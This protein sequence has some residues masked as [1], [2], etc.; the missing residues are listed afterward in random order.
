M[1]YKTN[2]FAKFKGFTLIELAAVMAVVGIVSVGVFTT[3]SEQKTSRFW[4]EADLRL[5]IAKT[6]LVKYAKRNKY[7]PCPDDPDNPDG[8]EDRQSSANNFACQFTTGLIPYQTLNMFVDDARDSWGNSLVYAVNQRA[9]V[10]ADIVSCPENSA[11]FFNN[12][13]APNF[14]WTTPP[15]VGSSVIAADDGVGNL[16]VCS[17]ASCDAST[18]AADVIADN[19]VVVIY[20][21][22]ENGGL[23]TTLETAEAENSDGD[24]FFVQ[25]SYSS[26]PFF[27]D[28]YIGISAN[29]LKERFEAEARILTSEDDGDDL[30]DNPFAN[31]EETVDG[32][33]GDNDRYSKIIGLNIGG[34]QKLDFDPEGKGLFD[35][36]EKTVTI[37]LKVKVE[38][39]WEDGDYN[40][41]V[42]DYET[43][44]TFAVGLNNYWDYDAGAERT[45]D[46]EKVEAIADA[47]VPEDGRINRTEG[48]ELF[49]IDENIYGGDD[50]TE[51]RLFYYDASD[52]SDDTWYEYLTYNVETVEGGKV[53]LN[54]GNFSTQEEETVTVSEIEGQL[55]SA[56]DTVP[57]LPDEIDITGII[58][59]NKP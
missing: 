12:Q 46:R 9:N 55:Y 59:A 43:K 3:Y 37:T 4:L 48:L 27:D 1:Q 45:E 47:G 18:A 20:A 26:S 7:L 36:G 5:D 32:G 19:L 15:V 42:G 8:I 30:I 58:N 28:R 25:E 56:P 50:P 31:L 33:N 49:G 17:S 52:D 39:D 16:R 24:A 53:E 10:P 21:T 57:A 6:A 11:C 35:D 44:D 54:F 41:S 22:N 34:R 51:R 38:G 14:D 40:S 29:E 2:N 23:N 13:A